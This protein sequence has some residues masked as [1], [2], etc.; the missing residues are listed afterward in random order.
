MINFS[1]SKLFNI[2]KK[3]IISS[4]SLLSC[5]LL[6][7][8]ISAVDSQGYSND[9]WETMNRHIFSFNDKVD[10]AVLK[11]IAQSYEFIFPKPVR[12]GVTHFFNNL[13]DITSLANSILQLDYQATAG[14]ASRVIN[15]T[16][17]GL[18]GIFD[19]A[20]PMGNP[21]IPRDFGSTLAHYKIQSGP[22]L[23]LP[24]FGPSTLRD[25]LAKL[26]DIALSPITYIPKES[27][28]WQAVALDIIQTRASYLPLEEQIKGT[29]T[30]LYTTIR[31][32][33][34]Q[35]RWAQLGTPFNSLQQEEV[36]ELFM[37]REQ[38]SQSDHLPINK[39][40]T[41]SSNLFSVDPDTVFPNKQ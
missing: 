41:N 27:T 6:T 37:P 28:H 18:G 5:L 1:Y 40:E 13:S 30:D 21:K 7:G 8:C 26:P 9:P 10:K 31:D 15:N 34:L 16:I 19:V 12:T 35:Q 11:P 3:C 14:I 39:E 24:F 29:T 4:T 17:F 36:D 22:Y 2:N 23:V 38:P 25:G 33:W 32:V 20:T